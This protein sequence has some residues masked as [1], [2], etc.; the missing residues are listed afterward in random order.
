MQRLLT[1]TIVA[2]LTT[3]AATAQ[4]KPGTGPASSSAPTLTTPV[5]LGLTRGTATD[6]TLT[7]TNLAGAD[8]VVVEG[9]D[10]PF[11]ITLPEKSADEKQLKVRC[12]VPSSVPIGLYRIRIATPWGISNF[13]PLCIDTFPEVEDDGKNTKKDAAQRVTLPCVVRGS[14]TAESADYYRFS[15]RAGQSLT[16]DC[17]ARRLGS[18]L[19]PVIILHDARTGRE[20]PSLYADD[21]PGLQADSRIVHTFKSDG[22]YL[23]EVRDATYRGGA[24]FVYRLRLSEAPAAT[25]AFPPVVESRKETEVR[26]VGPSVDGVE[27]FRVRCLTSSSLIPVR[28]GQPGWPVSVLGSTVPQL[29]E[30]EPNDTLKQAQRVTMPVGISARFAMKSDKDHYVFAA[31]KG[32]KILAECQTYELL[33]PTEVDL[34]VTDAKGNEVVRSDPQKLAA[35][36]EF[37]ASEDGDFTIAAEHLNY[38]FGPN[39]IYHLTIRTAQPEW[40]VTLGTDTVSVPGDGITLIPIIGVTRLHGFNEPIQLAAEPLEGSLTIP[41]TANP[42]AAA[43]LYLA[44]SA[45][46][47]ASKIPTTVEVAAKNDGKEPS[48]RALCTEIVRSGMGGITVLPPEWNSRIA[49]THIPKAPFRVTSE[50]KL[51]VTAGATVKWTVTASR[52][53]KFDAELTVSILGLPANVTAK[54]K[55]VAKGEKNVTWDLTA[56]A[57]AVAG[58]SDCY[59]RASAIIDGKE[60]VSI[61]GPYPLTVL[62]AKKDEPKKETPK[63]K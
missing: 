26:L 10:T 2:W 36:V 63:K 56:D 55:P 37:T 20:L 54:V 46:K 4:P 33:A 27:P 34:R 35:R 39:E 1:F 25:L 41:P 6:L 11:K 16:L 5:S 8:R 17:F 57:K 61:A 23:I 51:F 62:A 40:S 18:S 43:P 49:V 28:H 59:L 38:L 32:Q 22:E 53:E 21:T 7:G 47:T 44:V 12:E 3:T 48:R 9:L 29:V 24:D 14:V 15:V 45:S 52:D 42:T 58:V 19:D 30:Q 13:R 60:R 50:P 31:K